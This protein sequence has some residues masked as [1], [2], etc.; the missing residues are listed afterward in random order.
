MMAIIFFILL[1][2]VLFAWMD[3]RRVALTMFVVFLIVA[4]SFFL[5]DMTSH[6]AIQ[7]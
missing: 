5:S 1:L 7:L 4:L 2:A 3:M 6:L